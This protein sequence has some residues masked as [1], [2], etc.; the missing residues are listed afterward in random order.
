MKSG[1]FGYGVDE[2]IILTIVFFM[3][4]SSLGLW[5]I[6]DT[7]GSTAFWLTV[8]SPFTFVMLFTIFDWCYGQY[9]YLKQKWT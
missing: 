1:K 9:H 7:W 6:Y 8:T 4:L 2:V 5:K 3:G